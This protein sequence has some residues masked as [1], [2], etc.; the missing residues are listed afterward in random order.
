MPKKTYYLQEGKQDPIHTQWG[1]AWKNFTVTHNGKTVGVVENQKQLKQPNEFILDD[2]RRINVQLKTGMQAYLDIQVDGKPLPGSGGDPS[3]KVKGA[4]IY[5]L[6]MGGLSLIL[7]LI[8]AGTLRGFE[9]IGFLVAGEA[10]IFVG[11]GIWILMSKSMASVI[12]TLVLASIET[13]ASFAFA[14]EA[15]GRVYGVGVVKILWIVTL[16]RAISATKELKEQQ[17][18]D[19]NSDVLDA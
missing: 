13:V 12:V 17:P 8:L 3:T 10:L 19:V 9:E 18:I 5:T 2:G 7:G 16:V 6:V 1:L 11:L 15:G 14:I 4:A